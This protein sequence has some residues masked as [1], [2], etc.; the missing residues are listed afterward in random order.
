MIRISISSYFSSIGSHLFTILQ[1]ATECIPI[2]RNMKFLEQTPITWFAM[3]S[4]W[5]SLSLFTFSLWLF[6][7][8]DKLREIFVSYS[9][10]FFIKTL[11]LSSDVSELR[12]KYSHAPL[13]TSSY[14]A[15]QRQ[16]SIE[17]RLLVPC[18]I[19]TILFVVG[20]VFISQCSKHG[21]WMNWAVMVVF[22]TNSFVNPLL[23]LFFR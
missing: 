22:A 17:T 8:R 3:S 11:F 21:K 4:S 15:Q 23:Y 7:S 14:A 1:L 9:I 18:I 5:L 6:S 10:T 12:S 16:L 19:N 13:S 2:G 20:Q